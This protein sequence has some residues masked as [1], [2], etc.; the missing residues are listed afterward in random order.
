MTV[1]GVYIWAT[2]YG[3]Y[4]KAVG[5]DNP[6]L[7][8]KSLEGMN[9]TKDVPQAF[10]DLSGYVGNPAQGADGKA[11]EA[12][13]DAAGLLTNTIKDA[14]LANQQNYLN[15]ASNMIIAS[16]SP[17]PIDIGGI[18][19]GLQLW[20]PTSPI[21]VSPADPTVEPSPPAT[22]T[23]TTTTTGVTSHDPN[24]MIG[25]AGYG[26]SNF[27]ADSTQLPYEIEFENSPTATAPAQ[28]VDITDQLS[29]S[30]N[31]N[32]LQLT[33]V[34]FGSTYI[35]IPAGLQNYSTTVS[36][37]ENGET[38]NVLIALSLNPATGLLTGSFESIDPTTELPPANLLTG[39]L[40]PENGSGNGTGFVDFSI[41][42]KLGL[43]TGTLIN[44]VA[45]ITFD[46]G[47]IIATDQINDDDPGQGINPALE[48][49]VTIDSG[50]PTSTVATLP[51]STPPTF[52][53]N[54][55]GHDDTG[56]SGIASY[57]V[58][59]NDNGGQFTLWQ[60]DT[61]L[62]SA[63]YTGVAGQTYGFYSVAADN[64]DNVQPTPSSAQTSTTVSS[65]P[66]VTGISPATGPVGVKTNVTITGQN[67]SGATAVKFGTVAGTI[68]SDTATKIVVTS[69]AGSLGKVDITVTT[70]KGTSA[71]SA[72]DK[73]TFAP[74]GQ[75]EHHQLGG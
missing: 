41:L 21:V 61:T 4:A 25:P 39:F 46:Q 29:S 1:A 17:F 38:F 14:G 53:V 72:A 45:N 60:S 56:G 54:W 31:W 16:R 2:Q 58:Y 55:S 71:T 75:G 63:S 50:P 69:P 24:A 59:V 67:L 42:P 34:G 65:L 48:A 52:T 9:K 3:G 10:N 44:N 15:S 68:V 64:V 8:Q 19:S 40:P 47:E 23:T 13:G 35:S 20:G 12:A 18:L 6:E 37:T 33:A 74:H 66:F 49:P 51:S 7:G 30:F 27:V 43:T 26:T 28:R 70:S 73:F 32:T 36:M 62:T 11:A 5:T 22:V 57:S